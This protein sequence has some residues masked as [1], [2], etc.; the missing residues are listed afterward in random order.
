MMTWPKY[1][2]DGNSGHVSP[3]HVTEMLRPASP[4]DVGEG[5]PI[6]V[7][8]NDALLHLP[9]SVH[10]QHHSRRLRLLS[11]VAVGV[12]AA[13]ALAC[14]LF[15]P[16]LSTVAAELSDKNKDGS[17]CSLDKV[18]FHG[19]TPAGTPFYFARAAVPSSSAS[20]SSFP[21]LVHFSHSDPP[22][23]LLSCTGTID[24]STL[25]RNPRALNRDAHVLYLRQDA[26]SSYDMHAFLTNTLRTANVTAK[27]EII[28]LGDDSSVFYVA[29]QV[30][31]ANFRVAQLA[32]TKST[33]LNV[34]GVA[35]S[36]PA[37]T[38]WPSKRSSTKAALG[39]LLD[40]GVRVVISVQMDNETTANT[41]SGHY[42]TSMVWSRSIS[43]DGE[44]GFAKLTPANDTS[45][46][47]TLDAGDG[48]FRLR[49]N[50]NFAV[51]YQL[52][53]PMNPHTLLDLV[54][55]P[56]ARLVHDA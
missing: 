5:H 26:S 13:V 39:R 8:A 38:L 47:A 53:R 54:R 56:H 2:S 19:T 31:T 20:S 14:I 33:F 7:R 44:A 11:F 6:S 55:Q 12:C 10:H 49:Q 40:A 30:H 32:S 48:V 43:W 18:G 51:A 46:V 28:I 23:E 9:A 21:L 22:P 29:F 41:T 37:S 1:G 36:P 34:A 15:F 4:N 25:S 42:Y 52:P 27:R 16:R 50:R 17:S 3:R 35:F 24:A 45:V